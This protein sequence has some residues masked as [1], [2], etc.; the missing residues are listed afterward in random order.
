MFQLA[1]S[2]VRAHRAG[3]RVDL[4]IRGMCALL[5][6]R[7]GCSDHVHVRSVVGR[8]LE[9]ARCFW[10]HHAGEGLTLI[11]SADVMDRNLDRRVEVLV[12]ILN[13][14]IRRWLR[15]VYLQRYLD[16]VERTRV[17][18]PDGDYHRISD[19]QH[20]GP[21]VHQQFLADLGRR[22]SG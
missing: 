14:E 4:L 12:P 6:G 2:L 1:Q 7:K 22:R 3:V 16:D 20:P 9:H 15:D 21:D 13:P 19:P 10:F 17:M 11:G 5:P 8:F 18:T